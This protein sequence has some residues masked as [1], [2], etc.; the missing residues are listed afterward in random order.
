MIN[1]TLAKFLSF[2]Y[3]FL[4][5]VLVALAGGLLLLPHYEEHEGIPPQQLLADMVSPERYIT[6]D[7]LAHKIINGDPSLLLVDVRDADSYAIYSI[8]GA[9]NVPLQNLLDDEND[10]YI[11]Q[12][13]YNIVFISHDNVYA[14]QAWVLCKRLG[15]KNLHV[16]KGGI[17]AWYSTII[18]PP[19]PDATMPET[20]YEQYSFRKAA[21]MYFGVAYPQKIVGEKVDTPKKSVQAPAKKTVV[22]VKKKKKAP[23]EGGC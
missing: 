3:L 7:E 6:T 13:A 14:D 18:N 23:V 17:N 20:A 12:N 4:A 9:V 21:G 5:L 8:P 19:V 10:G 1:R 2:Q 22:P 15:Y 16:L 11:N